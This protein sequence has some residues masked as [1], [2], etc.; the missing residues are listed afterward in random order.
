MMMKFGENYQGNQHL[1]IS[2]ISFVLGGWTD[3]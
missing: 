1:L 2:F 3:S